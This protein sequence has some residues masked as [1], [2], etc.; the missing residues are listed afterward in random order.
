MIRAPW[1]VTTFAMLTNLKRLGFPLECQSLSRNSIAA[2]ARNGLLTI[3]GFS[4]ISNSIDS[5]RISDACNLSIYDSDWLHNSSIFQ[6]R[7]AI[8]D[9]S[10]SGASNHLTQSSINLSLHVREVNPKL[11]QFVCSRMRR[12]CDTNIVEVGFL[13]NATTLLVR[14]S[15]LVSFLLIV[16]QCSM[17]GAPLGDLGNIFIRTSLT[18]VVCPRFQNVC[19]TY[20]RQPLF[21]NHRKYY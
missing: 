17:V 21:F 3:S 19:L 5:F 11:K 15:S 6:I 7:A 2:R 10:S 12:L 9:A 8:R 14:N 16:L 20:L 4:E 18:L 13:F 1:N